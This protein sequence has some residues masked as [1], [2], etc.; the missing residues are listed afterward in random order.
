MNISIVNNQVAW[1]A[2]YDGSGNGAAVEDFSKTVNGGTTW[3]PGTVNN[4]TGLSYLGDLCN[5]RRYSLGMH[6]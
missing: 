5:Q 1:V 4:A 2:A 3:T 6:V